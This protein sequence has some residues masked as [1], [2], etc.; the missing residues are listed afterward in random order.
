MINKI[1]YSENNFK[2]RTMTW[3]HWNIVGAFVSNVILIHSFQ[4]KRMTQQK[5]THGEGPMFTFRQKM[6]QQGLEISFQVM[7]IEYKGIKTYL[8]RF[9]V[10][11]CYYIHHRQR[12]R[13][14][15]RDIPWCY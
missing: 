6:T 14:L 3:K 15:Y 1:Y 12:F 7:Q 4:P 13:R 10:N 2:N 8:D 5:I 11:L 9:W